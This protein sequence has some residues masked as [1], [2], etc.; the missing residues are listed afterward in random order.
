MRTGRGTDRGGGSA[1]EIVAV[2]AARALAALEDADR[3][4]PGHLRRVLPMALRHRRPEAV[5]GDTFDWEPDDEAR[6]Q[7]LFEV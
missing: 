4:T 3:V 1:G 6:L 2:L 5:H 7:D